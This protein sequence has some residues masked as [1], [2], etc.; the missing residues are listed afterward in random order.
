VLTNYLYKNITV[1]RP[2]KEQKEKMME[3]MGHKPVKPL[4]ENDM[5]YWGG[6]KPL[7]EENKSAKK[8]N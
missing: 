1:R 8:K 2:L 6:K 4:K 5:T 7:K 3:L